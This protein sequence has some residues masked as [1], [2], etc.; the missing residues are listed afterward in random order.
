L[1]IV[2][3][4]ATVIKV[5][6]RSAENIN[7]CICESIELLRNNLANGDFGENFTIPK[8]EPLFIKEIKIKR[9]NFNEMIYRNLVISG[10]LCSSG[11]KALHK[12]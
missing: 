8:I 5:C 11:S 1:I 6:P 3:I 12:V 9:G 10:E 2:K 4:T 7:E